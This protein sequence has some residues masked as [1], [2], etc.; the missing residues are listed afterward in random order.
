MTPE[1]PPATVGGD[2]KELRLGLVCYGGS[3][4]AIYMHGVTKELHRLVKGSVLAELGKRAQIDPAASDTVYAELF[5]ELATEEG[6]RTRAVVDVIAGTSAGGINGVYLAKALAHNLSQDSLRDLW[7]ARGDVNQLLK[8]PRFLPLV[9]PAPVLRAVR[10]E[11]VDRPRRRDGAMAVR[12]ARGYGRVA[13][14]SPRSVETLV[15]EGSMLDL[16]V[17]IT[18]F[19]GYQRLIA[20]D[21]PRLRPRKPPGIDRR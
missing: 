7:F 17:T 6:V 11:T 21:W 13:T 8:G 14:T 10:T 5:D 19:Y 4:L 9:E 3:S 20:L 16:F 12:R 1:Q 18:D 15:P 2:T